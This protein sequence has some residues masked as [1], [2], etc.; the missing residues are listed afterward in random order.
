MKFSENCNNFIKIL[1]LDSKPFEIHE[2]LPHTRIFFILVA[3]D[4]TAYDTVI[5][6]KVIVIFNHSTF[7]RENFL[8]EIICILKKPTSNSEDYHSVQ[9]IEDSIM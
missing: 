9:R 5:R 4:H 8:F 2:T 1:F 7:K 3:L 6:E